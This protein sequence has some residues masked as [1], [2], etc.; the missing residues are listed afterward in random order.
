MLM[1]L[2]SNNK[3]NK[4]PKNKHEH[5]NDMHLRMLMLYHSTTEQLKKAV[6]WKL[7][8]KSILL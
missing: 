4:N 3:N 5:K 7:S 1:M 6:F 8:I 2:I